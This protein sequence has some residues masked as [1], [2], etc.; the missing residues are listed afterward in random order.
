MRLGFFN[1]SGVVVIEQRSTCESF[2]VVCFRD[3]SVRCGVVCVFDDVR[4]A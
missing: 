1:V 3:D 2:H 4:G